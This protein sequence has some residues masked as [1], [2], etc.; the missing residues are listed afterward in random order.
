MSR[1]PDQ[2]I[3]DALRNGHNPAILQ[4]LQA[5]GLPDA[6]LVA[7]CL[8]QS[9]WNQHSGRP[10]EAGVKDYD[11][12]YCDIADLSEQAEAAVNQRVQA[13]MAGLG[14][15]IDVKNQARVHLWYP[16][17]FGHPYDR[18]LLRSKDGMD[19]F[20]VKCTCVGLRP[21]GQGSLELYAPN[22]LGN[23][24]DGILEPNPLCD[25][26]D[27]FDRKAASYRE[28]WD[29]LQVRRQPETTAP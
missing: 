27:L 29:W 23:L 10:A 25:H 15:A 17:R 4:R 6:W 21:Y 26:P 2:F 7:G 8:F 3:Q 16:Q 14:L 28:R 1:S 5:L 20:L 18:A 22:G 11:I 24:Y 12:F 9:V 13:A 19:R